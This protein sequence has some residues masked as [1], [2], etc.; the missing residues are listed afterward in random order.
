MRSCDYESS[1]RGSGEATTK[2]SINQK[3]IATTCFRKSRNDEST[4]FVF[5][6]RFVAEAKPK[7]K[8]NKE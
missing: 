5:A 8:Q 3:W 4:H 6:R 1:L 2:Q 7:T